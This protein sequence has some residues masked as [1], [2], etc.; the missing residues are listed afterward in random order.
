MDYK[1]HKD[2]PTIDRRVRDAGLRPTR[3]RVA[4]AHLLFAK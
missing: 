3:Q 1:V 2:S 4:L